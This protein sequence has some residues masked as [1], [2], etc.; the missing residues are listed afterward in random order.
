[1][2]FTQQ[3]LLDTAGGTHFISVTG[4]FGQDS[5]PYAG[6][7]MTI[8]SNGS[9][10]YPAYY[11]EDTSYPWLP[12]SGWIGQYSE[13]GVLRWQRSIGGSNAQ[14]SGNSVPSELL[15]A[16][17]LSPDEQYFYVVGHYTRGDENGMIFKYDTSGNVQWKKEIGNSSDDNDF[18]GAVTDSSGNLYVVGH[19]DPNSGDGLAHITKLNSSGAIQWQKKLSGS[20]GH[21]GF[22]HIAIDSSNNIYCCGSI[23]SGPGDCLLVKYNTSGSVQWQKRV[24]RGSNHWE[25]AMSMAVDSSGNVYITGFSNNS[26]NTDDHAFL[27]KF[28][29][30]GSFQWGRYFGNYNSNQGN[31]RAE[32][33][34]CDKNGNVYVIGR[35]KTNNSSYW[36]ALIVKLNSSGTVQWKRSLGIQNLQTSGYSIQIDSRNNVV[37]GGEFWSSAG[38]GSYG[39]RDYFLA[40]LP[41]DGSKTGTY[42]L[43][44]GSWVYQSTSMT[45]GSNSWSTSNAGRTEGNSGFSVSNSSLSEASYTHSSSSKII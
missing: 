10:Y 40:K 38:T 20:S 44:S 6:N 36:D 30:S 24:T 8:D 12:N 35:D 5:A 39:S 26:A 43:N 45:T 41:N 4:S 7:S 9:I 19:T 21:T 13:S 14:T 28:N 3:F 15:Y 29:S 16:S 23:D 11:R 2:A 31:S 42:S 27:A 32:S 22:N 37:I 18:Y 1:M 34:A 17:C 25:A 33:C